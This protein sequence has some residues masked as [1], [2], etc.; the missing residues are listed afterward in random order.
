MTDNKAKKRT[1]KQLEFEVPGT[2]EQVWQAIATGPGISSWLFPTQVEEREG[3][4]VKFQIG[5]G[6]ESSGSVT[7]W[8]PPNKFAY[9]ET[10]WSE[11]A[12]PLGTEFVIEARSGGTCVVRLVHSLFTDQERW[13]DELGGFEAGWSAFFKVLRLYLR[14]FPGEHAVPFRILGKTSNSE[15]EAWAT[16]KSSLRFE[17]ATP[18]QPWTTSGTDA[19]ALS[20]T[21]AYLDESA[22]LRELIAVLDQPSPGIALVG[23]AT[24]SQHVHVAI[25]FYLFGPRAATVARREEAAWTR[26]QEQ[27]FGAG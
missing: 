21:I 8:D 24:W 23:V 5:P 7:V 14:H 20:G 4:A 9:E 17:G 6:M 11:G 25:S 16:L 27:R 22:A 19:P 2:P 10:N 18:G 1:S 26:W 12:P 3:G 13:D 15:A